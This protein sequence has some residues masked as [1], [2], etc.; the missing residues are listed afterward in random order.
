MFARM[1]KKASV[2]HVSEMLPAFDGCWLRDAAGQ[3]YAS[4]L[5]IVAVDPSA[6][7]EP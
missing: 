5:R 3:R 2:V 7:Q 1:V 6:W 4:E